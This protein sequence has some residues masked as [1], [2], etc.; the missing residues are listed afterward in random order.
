ML[1]LVVALESE[2]TQPIESF[3]GYAH[4]HCTEQCLDAMEE[5]LSNDPS[6]WG[7]LDSNDVL[8]LDRASLES[9][10]R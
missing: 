8:F 2:T 7:T 5:Y 6:G 3:H 1:E 4:E 9:I 10:L